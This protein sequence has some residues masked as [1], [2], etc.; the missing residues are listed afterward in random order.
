MMQIMA[1]RFVCVM[2]ERNS[3]IKL[4]L[5]VRQKFFRDWILKRAHIPRSYGEFFFFSRE[6][7]KI[8][9]SIKRYSIIHGNIF[10]LILPSIDGS[11]LQTAVFPRFFNARTL[12]RFYFHAQ[13]RNIYILSKT[14]L[15]YDLS[16]K[17]SVFLFL[18][19]VFKQIFS[20]VLK[21]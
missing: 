5:R 11:C 14:D 15:P 7:A 8:A 6:R 20:S 9:E 21:I 19:R 4:T 3:P 16:Q 2:S 1:T 12:E 18:Q 13:F 17:R 10:T